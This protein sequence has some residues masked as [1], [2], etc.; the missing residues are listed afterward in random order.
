MVLFCLPTYSFSLDFLYKML[1]L[2]SRSSLLK[3]KMTAFVKDEAE[4][5]LDAPCSKSYYFA[6]MEYRIR[7]LQMNLRNSNASS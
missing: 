5:S 6:F 4:S 3:F 2:F 7:S 1:G